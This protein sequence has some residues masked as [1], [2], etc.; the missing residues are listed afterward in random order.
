[1]KGRRFKALQMYVK[2]KKQPNSQGN[3][4]QIA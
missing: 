1:M 3:M 4:L 2:Q